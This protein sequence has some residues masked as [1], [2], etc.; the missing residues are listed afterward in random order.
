MVMLC[1]KNGSL[2]R[3]GNGSQIISF[4]NYIEKS[5][6][7]CTDFVLQILVDVRNRCAEQSWDVFNKFL[8]VTPP[9]NGLLLS[10][11]FTF[12]TCLNL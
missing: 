9:L 2:T 5:C 12:K 11:A 4:M 8:E 1:Y 7:F 6:T 3:E 10:F